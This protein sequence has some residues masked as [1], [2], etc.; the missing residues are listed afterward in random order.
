MIVSNIAV[1]KII[2]SP[3]MTLKRTLVRVPVTPRSELGRVILANSIT[4]TP[5]T[6]SVRLEGDKILI[7][8]LSLEDAEEDLEGE[9]GRRIRDLER[10][11]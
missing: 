7:H 11:E 9:M 5:G 4:L 10:D 8:A 6:I 3:T 2:L 1:M